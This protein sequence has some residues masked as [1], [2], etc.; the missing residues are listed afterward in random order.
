MPSTSTTG[1]GASSARVLAAGPSTC[2]CVCVL[3]HSVS[4]LP[5][6]TERNAVPWSKDRLKAL[7]VRLEV[8]G[9][10]GKVYVTD[11]ESMEGDALAH[12]RKGK[13]FT[14]YEWTLKL[15]WRGESATDAGTTVDGET[16]IDDFSFQTAIQDVQM[17]SKPKKSSNEAK[18]LGSLMSSEGH[19]RIR[20]QLTE[21]ARSLQEE[22]TRGMVLPVKSAESSSSPSVS[23]VSATAAVVANSASSVPGS[24]AAVQ[25]VRAIT[26]KES[27]KC[28]PQD[29]FSALTNV[30]QLCAFTR[31]PCVSN[32]VQ[33][34]SFALMDG[35][36]TGTYKELAPP[37][38]LVLDWRMSSWPAGC[39]ST[40]TLR[41]E[42]KSDET[43]LHLEQT[44]VPPSEV[45]RTKSGWKER[46]WH[47]IR[48][49]FGFENIVGR[50]GGDDSDAD[51]VD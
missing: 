39:S 14:I 18:A 1:I 51:D 27:F 11:I 33:G 8:T 26:M 19:K 23:P 5:A 29:L 30:Q 50:R 42:A 28:A 20:E 7:L 32:A 24:A 17:S 12:N 35:A 46:Y 47:P 6:R 41:L 43:V 40:V 38:R 44:G 3:T 37:T 25:A 48:V 45:E 21:Y 15:R 22:F 16:E 34:G 9:P 31:S 36:V 13:V 2:V 49:V 10:A 4:V